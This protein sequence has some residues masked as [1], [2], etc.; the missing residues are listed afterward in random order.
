MLFLRSGSF[1]ASLV[2]GLTNLMASL[3]RVGNVGSLLHPKAHR[4]TVLARFNTP[5]A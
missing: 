2:Q 5:S 3:H 4:F 1:L